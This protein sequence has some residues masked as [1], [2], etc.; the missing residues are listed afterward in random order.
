MNSGVIALLTDFGLKD[1][2]VGIT[3]AVIAGIFPGVKFIDISH[4]VSSYDVR[5]AAFILRTSYNFF[6]QSTV[7]LAAIDPGVGSERK[8][9]AVKTKNYFFV[10]PDNGV[11]SLAVSADGI[12]SIVELTQEEYFLKQVSSTFQARDIFASVSA[13]LAKGVA[14]ERMGRIRQDLK[15]ISIQAPEMK[16][17]L[18]QGEIIFIDKFGN[19]VT[20]LPKSLLKGKEFEIEING[21][22]IDK[23]Y[24]SYSQAKDEELFLSQGSFGYIEVSVKKAKAQKLIPAKTGDKLILRFKDV[25]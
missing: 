24:N 20:N 5:Q 4:E 21:R 6:P 10:G 14:I 22:K 3:K 7:F 2:Y 25:N 17:H 13:F 8:A 12:E 16:N 23:I 11:L 19:L 9:L 18:M 15:H 1:N